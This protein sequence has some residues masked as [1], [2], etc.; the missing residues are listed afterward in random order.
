MIVI[1]K[2]GLIHSLSSSGLVKL[3]VVSAKEEVLG[4]CQWSCRSAVRHVKL[5]CYTENFLP[6]THM[7]INI[8]QQ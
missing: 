7:P 5:L 1:N 6:Y 3:S 2:L 4:C 8:R